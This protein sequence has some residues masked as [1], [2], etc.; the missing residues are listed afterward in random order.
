MKRETKILALALPIVAWLALASCTQNGPPN[1]A[2]D[3]DNVGNWN[4]NSDP[5]SWSGLPGT[6]NH[7]WPD[8][9]ISRQAPFQPGLT[10]LP[11]TAIGSER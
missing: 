9:N 1:A 8:D 11:P 2:S 6:A 3:A 10:P 4:S 7:D 5:D